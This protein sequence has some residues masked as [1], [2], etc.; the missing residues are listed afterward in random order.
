MMEKIAT[1]Q[2]LLAVSPTVN[3]QLLCQLVCGF[4]I[5]LRFSQD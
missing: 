1:A 4:D 5:S 2:S 3:P